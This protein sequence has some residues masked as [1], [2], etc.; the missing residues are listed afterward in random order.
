MVELPGI[1]LLQWN[2]LHK[3]VDTAHISTGSRLPRSSQ[4]CKAKAHLRTFNSAFTQSDSRS[5]HAGHSACDLRA[6]LFQFPASDGAFLGGGVGA[7][8]VPGG[9]EL[10]VSDVCSI[11][12]FAQIPF[13]PLAK[14]T[15]MHAKLGLSQKKHPQRE[16]C[17]P[18]S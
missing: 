16:A 9:F 18:L 8:A 14:S 2:A 17:Q 1:S 3:G 12:D 15:G 7:G 6:G 13:K 11:P 10:Q 5:G 4:A